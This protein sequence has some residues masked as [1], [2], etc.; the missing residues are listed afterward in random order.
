MANTIT[1]SIVVNFD[2]GDA[3]GMLIAEVDGREDG[4]NNGETSF[5]P[6][7]S[8]TF[9]IYASSNVTVDAIETSCGYTTNLGGGQSDESELLS[10]ASAREAKPGKPI[11]AEAIG[12]WLGVQGGAFTLGETNVTIPD[13]AVAVLKVDYKSSFVAHK[14]EGIPTELDG[15]TTFDVVIYVSGSYI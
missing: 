1:T 5:R 9:L 11:S 8:P 14:L 4:Y 2:P 10:F 12:K 6:G 15:E 3:G 13:K 7:D